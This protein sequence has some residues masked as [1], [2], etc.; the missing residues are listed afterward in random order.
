MCCGLPKLMNLSTQNYWINRKFPIEMYSTIPFKPI[1]KLHYINNC[2]YIAINCVVF[3]KNCLQFYCKFRKCTFLGVLPRILF[4]RLIAMSTAFFLVFFLNAWQPCQQHSHSYSF[5]MLNS[6]VSS[7]LPPIIFESLTA[8][9]AA[10]SLLLF[11][12]V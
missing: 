4:E 7:I 8:L 1:L 5:W 9:S 10:F 6:S 11:L 2:L 12:K 3:E